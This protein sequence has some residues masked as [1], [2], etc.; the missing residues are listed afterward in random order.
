MTRF[1]FFLSS[2]TRSCSVCV[3]TITDDRIAKTLIKL[4]NEGVEVRVVTDNDT[5]VNQGSDIERLVE[6]GIPVR[7]DTTPYHMHNKFAVLDGQLV[8]NGS[9]NWTWSAS[10][11]NNENIMITNDMEF[12]SDY[13][14]Y[15]EKIW[16]QF[17]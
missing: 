1:L 15:F 14:D 4:H 16:E 11:N 12:V 10:K 2:A 6:A 9:F 8:I 5:S 13:A 3:F 17:A 7:M